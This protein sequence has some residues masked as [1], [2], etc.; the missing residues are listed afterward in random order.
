MAV[1]GGLDAETILLSFIG[2][3]MVGTGQ[4]TSYVLR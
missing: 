2:G 4:G 1:K 3:V